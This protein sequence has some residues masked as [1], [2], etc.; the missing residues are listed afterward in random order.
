MFHSLILLL[1]IRLLTHVSTIGLL[2]G[3]MK[4]VGAGTEGAEHDGVERCLRC[5]EAVLALHDGLHIPQGPVFINIESG[6]KFSVGL[7][8]QACW[9]HGT[10]KWLRRRRPLIWIVQSWLWK[11]H[12]PRR[13]T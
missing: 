6:D 11:E 12:H 2:Q 3:Y 9:L 1:Y 5:L 8:V 13:I 7:P 10:Y 4:F